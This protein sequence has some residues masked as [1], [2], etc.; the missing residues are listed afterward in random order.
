VKVP[1]AATR[2]AMTELEKGR[3]KRFASA[4]ELFEDPG[5]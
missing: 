3:G 1:N 2:R 5:I 4:D